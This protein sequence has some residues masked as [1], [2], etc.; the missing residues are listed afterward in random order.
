M[1]ENKCTKVLNEK[2]KCDILKNEE[3]LHVLQAILDNDST[4]E[5]FVGKFGIVIREIKRKTKYTS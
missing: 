3:A 1:V 2:K 5:V 4:A